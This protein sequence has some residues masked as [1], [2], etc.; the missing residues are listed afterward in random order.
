MHAADEA[1]VGPLGAAAGHAGMRVAGALG[2]HCHRICSVGIQVVGV[3]VDIV[4]EL[5]CIFR[6]ELVLLVS[7]D[8]SLSHPEVIEH[9]EFLCCGSRHLEASLGVFEDITFR[10]SITAPS[11]KIEVRPL[12]VAVTS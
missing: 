1:G 12:P 8:G 7:V 11:R 3:V 9:R 2:C 10:I 4:C 5:L 6:V